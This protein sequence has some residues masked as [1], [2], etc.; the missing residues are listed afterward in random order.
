MIQWRRW[1]LLGQITSEP[2]PLAHTSMWC[3]W[4]IHQEPLSNTIITPLDASLVNQA[5]QTGQ[6]ITSPSASFLHLPNNTHTKKEGIHI[7]DFISFKPTFYLLFL[8]C[9]SLLC[10]TP[11]S[12]HVWARLLSAHVKHRPGDMSPS[13]ST[14]PFP[15]LHAPAETIGSQ[16]NPYSRINYLLL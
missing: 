9:S 13:P 14:L 7:R 16:D 3:W 6:F 11:P 12:F 8:L 10:F 5:A 1:D 15:S 2:P 4:D